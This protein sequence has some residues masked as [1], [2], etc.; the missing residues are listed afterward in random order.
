MAV[1]PVQEGREANLACVSNLAFGRERSRSIRVDLR[2]EKSLRSPDHV[3]RI[4]CSS[5][6]V[7][8]ERSQ[9]CH[10]RLFRVRNHYRP[11]VCLARRFNA[12]PK[13]LAYNILVKFCCQVGLRSSERITQRGIPE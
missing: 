3:S 5:G 4:E 7:R 8:R 10:S 13:S 12:I 2:A 11:A 6:A 1:T 9:K